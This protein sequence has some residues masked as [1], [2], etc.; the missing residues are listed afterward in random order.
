[1]R[2]RYNYS[3][4][5]SYG[6]ENGDF[7]SGKQCFGKGKT[8]CKNYRE[9]VHKKKG[10]HIQGRKRICTLNNKEEVTNKIAFPTS[11]NHLLQLQLQLNEKIRLFLFLNKRRINFAPVF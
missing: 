4:N 8:T 6:K 3:Y 5:Y 7:P 9:N 2:A 1:M 11:R 10:G